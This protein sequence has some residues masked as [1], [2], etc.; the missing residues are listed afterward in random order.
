MTNYVIADLEWIDYG[1]FINPTQISAVK[2]NCNWDIKSHFSEKIKPRDKH[3]YNWKHMAYK[4]GTA[5]DFLSARS[6]FHVFEDFNNWLDDSDVILWW[7]S[8]GKEKYFALIK[9]M[10]KYEPLQK[11]LILSEYLDGY[12]DGKGY[13]LWS[14]YETAD[15]L[16]LYRK[17][18]EHNSLVDVITIKNILK[19]V[20]FQQKLLENPPVKPRREVAPPF[21]GYAY[22]KKA[23]VIHLAGG[24]C[25]YP[26][27]VLYTSDLGKYIKKKIPPCPVCMLKEY[28]NSKK[29]I[30]LDTVKRMRCKFIYTPHSGIFHKSDCNLL[31]NSLSVMGCQKYATAIETGRRPCKICNPTLND[32]QKKKA[33]RTKSLSGKAAAPSV[34]NYNKN[35]E[36]AFKRLRQAKEERN[37]VNFDSL[38]TENERWDAITLTSTVNAFFAGKGYDNF[39]LKNCPKLSGI[40]GIIGFRTFEAATAAGY[41]P[42]KICKPDKKHNVS[43]S[44]PVTSKERADEKVLD[45]YTHCAAY[46]YACSQDDKYFYVKTPVGKWKI[47][48]FVKPIRLKH[49]NLVT[50]GQ[51]DEYH[52]QPRIFLSLTDAILYI[53]KHDKSLCK[54]E[55]R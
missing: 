15:K 2:V 34:K 37:A 3:F 48:L 38:K 17:G 35:V 6:A 46:G 41:T 28:K 4:G 16:N 7:Y 31:H 21:T 14:L 11:Q 22:D 40:R 32:E 50:G 19:A 26:Q 33:K 43:L 13:N 51:T 54:T 53:H 45:L 52:D 5:E 42:C 12:L 36:K 9:S 27:Y 10:F 29:K 47:R 49:I 20:N 1:G 30:Y 25:S 44:I 23:N 24:G 55:R 8:S 39:H 18:Q